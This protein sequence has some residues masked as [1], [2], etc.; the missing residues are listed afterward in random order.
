M[1]PFDPLENIR[2]PKVDKIKDKKN[3]FMSVGIQ[4]SPMLAG[5]SSSFYSEDVVPIL[6]L[7]KN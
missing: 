6:G 1:F 7:L 4:N 2:K 3:T 5:S